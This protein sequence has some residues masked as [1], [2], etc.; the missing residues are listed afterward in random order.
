KTVSP[1]GVATAP[2]VQVAVV[3]TGHE[4]NSAQAAAQLPAEAAPQAAPGELGLVE[5][6][7]TGLSQNPDLVTVRGTVN[8]SQA[9]LGVARTYPF[10]PT[11]QIRV[12]PYNK[13]QNGTDASTYNYVLL[14][15]QF[16]LCHQRRYRAQNAAA[17]VDSAR[18]AVQQAELTN[19]A[20]TEQL[21][22]TA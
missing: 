2:I 3:E 8:V 10:N 11:V 21:F 13:N 9:G 12:L 15:Q 1:S 19:V 5:A 6:I 4:A 14:W 7:E 18:L 20:M 22:F 16:E 17:L